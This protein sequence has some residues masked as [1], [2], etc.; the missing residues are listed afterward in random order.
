MNALE[1]LE[2]YAGASDRDRRAWL[3]ERDRGITATQVRDLRLGKISTPRL[4]SLKLGWEVDTFTGNAFTD[5]GNQREIVI[6]A[7]LRDV[8]NMRHET[9]VFHAPDEPRFLASPDAMGV[10]FDEALRIAEIKTAGEEDIGPGSELFAQ[11]GYDAQVQWQMRVTGADWCLFAWEQRLV[12]PLGGF[13][14]GRLQWEWVQRD[15]VMIAELEELARNF[16]AALDEAA[17]SAHPVDENVTRDAQEYLAALGIERVVRERKEAAYRLL[18]TSGRSQVADDIRVTYTPGRVEKPG[19]VDEID[20]AQAEAANPELFA[21]MQRI[22]EAWATHCE[23]YTKHLL[24]P[25]HSF[26]ARVT[27]T[28]LGKERE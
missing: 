9:R 2:K 4:I 21:E 14:P 16:L 28:K 6:A 24:V 3:A 23:Q 25:G 27:V 18:L 5:W 20:Y 8:L 11:Y 22:S 17:M 1:L 13:V 10:D 26:P 12:G 19:E 7:R 15:E